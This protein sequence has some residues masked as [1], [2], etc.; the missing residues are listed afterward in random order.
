MTLPPSNSRNEMRSSTEPEDAI[1]KELQ[2]LVV[3]EGRRGVA[4][5]SVGQRLFKQGPIG[6]V[7]AQALLERLDRGR[8]LVQP[9]PSVTAAP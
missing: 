3:R 5:A 9:R 7:M 4:G 6:E 8:P 1:A 2:H